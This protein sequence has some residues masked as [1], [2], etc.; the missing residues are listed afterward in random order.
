MLRVAGV[1]FQIVDATLNEEAAKQKLLGLHGTELAFELARLKASSATGRPED[2]V[3]GSDQVLELDT[4]EML[5]KPR[6]F[7]DARDHLRRM[8]G[9]FHRL[10][11]AASIFQAGQEI[12]SALETATLRM[13][14]L[15]EAFIQSYL[16]QEYEKIRWSVGCYRIEGPGI[17]LFEEIEGSHFA[18]LG[19]PLLPLLSELRERGLL[20]S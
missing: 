16:T 11:S 7:E 12:W 19:M 3:L 20:R 18:I 10:H 2:I 13:R 6:S 1:P 9:R 14:T 5:S 4:G 8:S 17:Q 15:S